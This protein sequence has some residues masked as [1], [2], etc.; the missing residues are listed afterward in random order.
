MLLAQVSS[1]PIAIAMLLAVA[2]FGACIPVMVHD[3]RQPLR[4]REPKP[5]VIRE[6]RPV[7]PSRQIV[8]PVLRSF[9]L[10]PTPE[11]SPQPA[12]AT[13]HPPHRTVV[14]A[15][16]TFVVLSIW[17]SRALRL[18]LPTRR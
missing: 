7:K 8:L 18:H 15:V 9:G 16:A 10:S 5:V 17:S 3:S 1:F 2:A 4:R 14:I 13:S 11:P 6:P 12:L